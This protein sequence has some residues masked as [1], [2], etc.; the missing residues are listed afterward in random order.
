M[1]ILAYVVLRIS[2]L[3]L[4]NGNHKLSKFHS[5]IINE[6]ESHFAG[7]N[8]NWLMLVSTYLVSTFV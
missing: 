2:V 7:T 3:L 6:T 1:P 4:P 8:C 5:M